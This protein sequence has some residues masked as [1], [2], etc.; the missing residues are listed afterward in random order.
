MTQPLIRLALMR[1]SLSSIAAFAAALSLSACGGGGGGSATPGAASL[2]TKTSPGEGDAT[3]TLRYPARFIHLSSKTLG[4]SA[5]RTA[6]AGSSR[7]PAYVNPTNGYQI[8]VT[9]HE[10]VVGQVTINDPSTGHSYFTIGEPGSTS[11]ADG[12]STF[13]VPV[14]SGTY[15]TGQFSITE[16]DTNAD[17]LAAGNNSSY[18][19]ANGNYQD[20]SFTILPGSTS[21]IPI[22][23]QMNVRYI[24]VTT[25]IINGSDAAVLTSS[26][27]PFCVFGGHDIYAFPVDASGGA[28]LPTQPVGYGGGDSN[29]PYP[30]VPSV[31]LSSSNPVSYPSNSTLTALRGG[32]GWAVSY[33]VNSTGIDAYFS[34]PYQYGPNFYGSTSASTYLSNG[35]G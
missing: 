9:I 6:N 20:G 3:V 1:K 35:C 31:T 17:T 27:Q 22:T 2:L 19:D 28:L 8:V 13:S 24:A 21:S 10:P 4:A 26:L 7:A 25:D 11:N 23:M 30:G 12:S 32:V 16:Y 34:T 5:K 18:T 14:P 33:D 29:N 15:S